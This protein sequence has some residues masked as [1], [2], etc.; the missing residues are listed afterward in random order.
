M[1]I[2]CLL[3]VLCPLVCARVFVATFAL[4]RTSA[5]F[6][7]RSSSTGRFNRCILPFRLCPVPSLAPIFGLNELHEHIAI[8]ALPVGRIDW[9]DCVQSNGQKSATKKLAIFDSLYRLVPFYVGNAVRIYTYG[10]LVCWRLRSHSGAA[11]G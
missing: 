6:Q 5:T 8:D 4:F 11:S 2:I 9:L 7:L 1:P 10:L 3:A